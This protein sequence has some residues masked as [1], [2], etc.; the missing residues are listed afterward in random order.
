MHAIGGAG[1]VRPR[2]F[3]GDTSPAPTDAVGA[4]VH[5]RPD[6]SCPLADPGAR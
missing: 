2:F 3:A 1:S 6:V 4:V 5:M